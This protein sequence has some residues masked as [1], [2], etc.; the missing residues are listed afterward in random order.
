MGDV[1][2]TVPV[3]KG[4]LKHN[5][6]L[7]ITLATRA[8]Y[9]P[10]FE[11]IPRLHVFQCDF[12]ERHKGLYGIFKL[13]Q[14]LKSLSRFD[15][16]IDLHSV[17]RSWILDF[18]FQIKG[19]S[20]SKLKKGRH[21]KKRLIKGSIF[22]Q[23]KTTTDRYLDVF[24]P[25]NLEFK[26][27]SVPVI[28]LQE[29]YKSEADN[30]LRATGPENIFH[31]GLAPFALHKLKTW[32]LS[33]TRELLK[34]IEGQ[35]NASVYLFGGGPKEISMLADL[36]NDYE[37]CYTMAGKLS[38]GAEMAL[39]QNMRFMI[40]MDSSNMHLS[41]LLGVKTIALWGATHPY[42]GFQAYQQK[43]E[44]DFQIS[45]KELPC[46]PCTVFGKGKCKR[47]DFACM[48]WLTP[49]H[50]FDRLMHMDKLPLRNS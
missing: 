17:L 27:P 28:H 29:G 39:M 21:E 15:Y 22:K 36:A 31:I 49:Q 7:S 44:R 32:P 3:L 2:L 18:L 35:T 11:D 41:S 6:N 16:I 23:L 43:K 25:L 30:F 14:E 42:A 45:K 20:V 8:L 40:T 38:I 1:A 24:K 13:Y 12:Q 48:N 9:K 46:R 19:I 33:H 37:R 4:L 34:M 50:I 5:D 47:K 26:Y 10:F